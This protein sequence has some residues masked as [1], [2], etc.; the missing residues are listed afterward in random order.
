MFW[1][2]SWVREKIQMEIMKHAKWMVT[3]TQHSRLTEIQL[4][5]LMEE[6]NPCSKCIRK[7]TRKF[8]FLSQ[9]TVKRIAN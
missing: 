7:K 3:K 1:N 5:Q 2:Y 4:K 9:E 6:K 8:K